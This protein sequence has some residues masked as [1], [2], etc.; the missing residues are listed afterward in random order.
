ME[1]VRH[2]REKWLFLL[3]VFG[4]GIGCPASPSAGEEQAVPERTGTRGYADAVPDDFAELDL[5]SLLA[6]PVVESASRREQS[7]LEAPSSVSIITRE[8]IEASGA[9]NLAELLRRVPGVHLIQDGANHYA[10]GIR[11]INRLQNNRTLVLIDGVLAADRLVGNQIW[12]SLPVQPGDIER[13]EVI[14][15]PGS[16]L[17]GADAMS[18]VIQIVTKRAL[19]HPGLEADAWGQ[20]NMMADHPDGGGDF[21]LSNSGGAR[22]AVSWINREQ[23]LGL[24]LGAGL[25]STPPWIR[26]GDA[27]EHGPYHYAVT[28]SLDYRPDSDLSLYA[29][30][31][32]ASSEYT[33]LASKLRS[34]AVASNQTAAVRLEK[35]RLFADWLDLT[36]EINARRLSNRFT[37]LEEEALVAFG[38]AGLTNLNLNYDLHGRLQLDLRMFDDRNILT[39]GAESTYLQVQEFYAS[40]PWLLFTGLIL[41][42]ET[43]LLADRSLILSMGGRL[44]QIMAR[45]ENFGRIVYRHFSPRVSVIWK[46]APRHSLRLAGASSFRTPQPW[47]T[48]ADARMESSI[49]GDPSKRLLVGNPRLRPEQLIGMEAGYRGL[50]FDSLRVDAVAFVQ[51]VEGLID[52]VRDNVLP[53]IKENLDDLE[54]AGIELGL[55][56]TPSTSLSAYL[57]YTFTWTRDADSHQARKEW[58]VHIWSLGAELRLAWHMRLNLDAYLVFDYQPTIS[59]VE[60]AAGGYPQLVWERTQA[61]DHA[62]V[63]L[64]LGRFFFEEKVE[65]FVMAKNLAAF[66][67]GPDGLRTYP[68]PGVEP[69]GG[70]VLAGVRLR[71][72]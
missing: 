13:I 51:R 36:V 30:V 23:T 22:A 54:Q 12:R 57:N 55:G 16:T 69:I 10:I 31:N 26:V 63:N 4:L 56:L 70:A 53:V 29:F 18:G 62:F 11:G 25:V 33:Y 43:K 35:K 44:E 37:N 42:N 59:S 49:P 20:L 40:K 1:N 21:W 52:D 28:A 50:L 71:G 66:F 7:L 58:P 27:F 15:G 46:L 32:H 60:N 67:R 65:A 8:Q 17:Y 39:L 19:D 61:A 9:T 6:T 2:M 38:G 68:H 48:F 14:R 3:A 5:E 45:E 34:L 64:R 41:H 24:R 72:M 47:E